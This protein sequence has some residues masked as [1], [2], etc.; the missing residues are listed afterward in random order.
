[1]ATLSPQLSVAGSPPARAIVNAGFHA[2]GH[3]RVR[4]VDRLTAEV[5]QRSL[6]DLT[7]R[8]AATRFGRDYGFEAVRS[9]D[10]FQRRVPLSTYEDLWESYLRPSYPV[11]DDLAWPGRI[12]Y[13][14][15]TSGTT[16]GVTKYIPVSHEMIR[17]NTK[18]AKT[19]IAAFLS[20]RPASRLF[21]G[22]LFFLGGASDL[23]WPAPGVG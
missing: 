14:A 1:M 9:I 11:F 17:S 3:R 6:L 2:F 22:K 5:Q 18:A 15:L 7:A 23:E 12:P 21:R 16:T 8:A 20:A 13:I 19:M 10:D 4:Q